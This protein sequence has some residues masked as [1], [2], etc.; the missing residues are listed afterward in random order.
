MKGEPVFD[1][2]L[3]TPSDVHPRMYLKVAIMVSTLIMPSKSVSF[4]WEPSAM[5]RRRSYWSGDDFQMLAKCLFR[6][7]KPL[8]VSKDL[9]V[10][11]PAILN[12]RGTYLLSIKALK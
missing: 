12:Q 11:S 10:G 6:T 2:S 3:P 4:M 1:L 9:S 7:W 8:S 5:P